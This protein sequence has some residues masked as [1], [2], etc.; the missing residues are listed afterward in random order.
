MNLWP[1]C[2]QMYARLN[3]VPF[4]SLCFLISAAHW[5]TPPAATPTP[6][7]AGG[8]PRLLVDGPTP[9][10][11]VFGATP[12]SY[13]SGAT[14]TPPRATS[15]PP[16][17]HNLLHLTAREAAQA[18]ARQAERCLK[19]NFTEDHNTLSGKRY[20][21][22]VEFL[23]SSGQLCKGKSGFH[24]SKDVA[25]E[26]ACQD[27]LRN[28]EWLSSTSTLTADAAAPGNQQ[29]VQPSFEPNASITTEGSRIAPPLGT[30]AAQQTFS[31]TARSV[32]HPPYYEEHPQSGPV[33]SH[34]E[35][36]S[37]PFS[38]V[39]N[40]QG[41]PQ[42]G[43]TLPTN[44]WAQS[45]VATTPYANYQGYPQTANTDHSELLSATTYHEGPSY[46]NRSEGKTPKMQLKEYCEQRQWPQPH[47]FTEH[48]GRT[49]QS[50][51][52]VHGLG[53][54]IGSEQASKKKAE[55]DAAA[56]AISQLG[57]NSTY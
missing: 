21:C 38:T 27:L 26:D 8:T 3:L 54:V 36:Q 29:R 44:N 30:D 20:R 7:V 39:T 48:S 35:S 40:Y 52:L 57:L 55:H 4:W 19:K 42:V 46:S 11:Y 16:L 25:E 33:S 31:V 14:P 37:S 51:V 49:F 50:K 10:P 1:P 28:L 45:Q 22:E 32:T 13:M 24:A 15:L 6:G 17:T 2:C 43:G 34:D 56:K 53:A 41:Q 47:Y 18:A 5:T 23:H 9:T 12:P